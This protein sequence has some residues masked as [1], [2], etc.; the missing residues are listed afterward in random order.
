MQQHLSHGKGKRRNM[1]PLS[2]MNSGESAM[3][4]RIGGSDEVK[5]HLADLGFVTGAEITVMNAQGNGNL[6]VNLKD[7]RLA[8]TKELAGKILVSPV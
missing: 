3:I 2:V 5:Q 6:I 4:S 7:S 1:I 8:L